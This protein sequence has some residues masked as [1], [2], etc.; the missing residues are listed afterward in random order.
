MWHRRMLSSTREIPCFTRDFSAPDPI[1]EAGQRRV[2]ELMG[3]GR[4]FRYQGGGDED[5][6]LLEEDF[7][8]MLG[9]RFAIGLNS[10]GSALFLALKVR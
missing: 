7:A 3:S 2:S 1:P 6:S 10:C 8:R 5:A 9:T 4:I